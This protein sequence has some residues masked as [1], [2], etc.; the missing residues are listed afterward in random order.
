[1]EFYSHTTHTKLEN[2]TFY[3]LWNLSSLMF[4]P[5]CDTMCCRHAPNYQLV[6]GEPTAETHKQKLH[7]FFFANLKYLLKRVD[8]D[9][10][11]QTQKVMSS[12]LV[13]VSQTK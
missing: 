10:G 8:G 4:A 11:A 12:M 1:M 6:W 7:L 9:H 3:R 2:G 5:R 13:W